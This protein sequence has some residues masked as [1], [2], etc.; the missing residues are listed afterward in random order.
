[1]AQAKP[2][3]KYEWSASRRRYMQNGR[4]V[5]E[6]R[7]REGLQRAID[8]SKAKLGELSQKLIDGNVSAAEWAVQMREEIKA[9]HRAAAMLANGG[10]LGK[11]EISALGNVLKKQY[12]YLD[13]FRLGI[14]NDEIKLNARL[15]AR[16]RLYAQ[17]VMVTYQKAVAAREEQAGVGLYKLVLGAAENCDDC[18]ADA[19]LGFVEIGSLPEIGDRACVSNCR[20]SWT[21]Q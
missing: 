19:A 5:P 12:A 20:C 15:V 2:K 18:V 9:A 1:M 7:V 14:E 17:A 3:A 11:S 21:F 4:A 13:K 10:K 16:A 8:S 6:K